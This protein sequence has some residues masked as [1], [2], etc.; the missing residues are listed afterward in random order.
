[1]RPRRWRAAARGAASCA[2]LAVGIPAA[3][4][5]SDWEVAA[6]IGPAFPLYEQT[7]P[8]DPGPLTVAGASLEQRGVFSLHARGGLAFGG[9]VAW[10]PSPYVGLELRLDTADVHV[11]TQ[12]ARY[13]VRV[14]VPPL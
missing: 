13:S 8:Y 5:A 3:A 11:R 6:W 4:S 14:H 12:G 7:F 2:L 1:M 9:A 10:H